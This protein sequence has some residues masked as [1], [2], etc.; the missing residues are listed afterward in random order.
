MKEWKFRQE[1]FHRLNPV[2]PDM[3]GP[4]DI[5]MMKST[6]SNNIIAVVSRY[7]QGWI[8]E[9]VI[10]PAKSYFVAIVYS[11]LLRDHFGENPYMVLNDS[12]LLHQ[13][14]PYFIP[15]EDAI[16]I[17]DAILD[18]FGWDFDLTLGEIPDVQ[19]YF[20]EEFQINSK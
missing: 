17:Y 19:N 6:S 20:N 1:L 8:P 16:H 10:Y 3:Y 12:D 18:T 4:D 9:K 5:E 14:D 15:Y 11:R 7:M 13:N 2:T